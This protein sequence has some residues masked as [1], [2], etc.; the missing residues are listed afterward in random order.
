MF[1]SLNLL[2]FLSNAKHRQSICCYTKN[3]G[4][5]PLTFIA[6]LGSRIPLFY[7]GSEI[8]DLFIFITDLLDPFIFIA[9]PGSRIWILLFYRADPVTLILLRIRDTLTF[10]ADPEGH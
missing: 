5:D 7:R 3:Q 2:H 10:I 6:N 9:D 4:L 8:P 1:K